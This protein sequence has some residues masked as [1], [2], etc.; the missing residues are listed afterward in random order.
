ME[1]IESVINKAIDLLN[2]EDYAGC[3]KF[4]ESAK[5]IFKK[6]NTDK[7]L[8]YLKSLEDNLK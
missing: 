7:E 6:A 1:N 2:M 4:L 5:E 3:K 8:K